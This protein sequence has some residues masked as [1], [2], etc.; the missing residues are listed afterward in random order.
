MTIPKSKKPIK[1]E[2]L[3]LFLNKKPMLLGR[4]YP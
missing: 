4:D 2:L 3:L 1:R